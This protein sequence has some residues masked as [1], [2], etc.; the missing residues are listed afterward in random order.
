MPNHLQPNKRCTDSCSPSKCPLI[1][2]RI[3]PEDS[4][5]LRVHACAWRF[6]WWSTPPLLTLPN[7]G[8]LLLLWVQ[9]SQVPSTVVFCSPS[10]ITLSPNPSGC[11]HTANASPLPGTDSPEP[12]SQHP[13]PMW[14][15][16]AVVSGAVELMICAALILLCPPH[17]S[18]CTFPSDFEVPLSQLISL[19]VRWPL[20]VWDPFLFHSS[21]S[22]LDSFSHF[23][24]FF[25]ILFYPV[26]WRVSCSF[27]RF[28]ILLPAFS[29]SSVS[30]YM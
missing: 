24:S 4:H 22:H 3:V 6:L 25:F 8:D 15:S 2:C 12:E 11:L 27:W 28:K 13:A 23:L 26:M 20:R 1:T 5:P 19:S 9:I 30:F 17:S 18:C 29:R 14:K 16:Q 21:L 10:H 7:N